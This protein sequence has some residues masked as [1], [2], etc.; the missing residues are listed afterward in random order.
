[1]HP[2]SDIGGFHE[3]MLEALGPAEDGEP[4]IS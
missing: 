3:P 4:V 2:V 1:M